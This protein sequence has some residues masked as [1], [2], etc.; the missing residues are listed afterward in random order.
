M[1]ACAGGCQRGVQGAAGVSGHR[2]GVDMGADDAADC[3]RL[4]VGGI[5]QDSRQVL[6]C[7]RQ[8]VSESAK[9]C[10]PVHEPLAP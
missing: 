9:R 10:R 5:V 6:S 1:C 8:Q 7:A 2:L 4:Q 3:E